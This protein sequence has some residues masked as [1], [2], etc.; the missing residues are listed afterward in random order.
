M[1]ECV[2]F[3]RL[4]IGTYNIFEMEN[5]SIINLVLMLFARKKARRLVKEYE[6]SS[7]IDRYIQLKLKKD[8]K[9]F[10]RAVKIFKN[11]VDVKNMHPMST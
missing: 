4:F 3:C 7:K 1:Y 8:C 11:G 10:E 9:E 6:A 5:F 2:F